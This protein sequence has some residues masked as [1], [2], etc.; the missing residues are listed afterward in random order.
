MSIKDFIYFS[1]A[2]RR[3][4]ATLCIVACGGIMVYMVSDKI[5]TSSKNDVECAKSFDKRTKNRQQMENWRHSDNGTTD[6]ER[7]AETFFFDPNTADSAQLAR[8]GLRHWQIRNIMRYRQHGGTY[9]CKEDFARVYGLTVAEYRRLAP[10][11]RIDADYLPAASLPEVK[12]R[13]HGYETDIS[14]DKIA[15]ADK[16]ASNRHYQHK[17]GSGEQIA[18]NSADTAQLMRI[19]GIGSYYAKEIVKLRDR[20]GGFANSRQLLDIEDFPMGAVEYISID[21]SKIKRLNINR[22][23][24]T[25]LKRHPYINYYQARAIIDLRRLRGNICSV[26]ELSELKDFST[27]DISRLLPYLEF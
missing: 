6:G 11:I 7:G 1:L 20:L 25:Q 14:N 2:D 4:I 21:P 19:P 16:G 3:V 10:Y 23:S 8:L 22:L 5:E 18:V 24:L 26:E 15:T 27:E 13:R 17:I 9:S 12:Q